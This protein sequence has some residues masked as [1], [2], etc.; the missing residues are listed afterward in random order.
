M[1]LR[2]VT[3]AICAQGVVGSLRDAA[4]C[5]LIRRGLTRTEFLNFIANCP[6]S[7]SRSHLM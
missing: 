2:A 7:G 3:G 5:L 6:N 4:R 1:R